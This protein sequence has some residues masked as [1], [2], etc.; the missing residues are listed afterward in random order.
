MKYL[1]DTHSLIW[2]LTGDAQ[3]SNRARQLIEAEE[4]ELLVSVASLWEM[5]IKFSIGKLDLGQPFETLFPQQ[6]ENNSIE[7]LSIAVEH[8]HT[9]CK[10]P[11][12]HRDPFDRL[13]IAQAQVEK[14]PVVSVDT[15]FDTYGTRREW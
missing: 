3:L 1:L 9:V 14:L 8:L 4:N 13:I 12:Y 7:I 10:L 2:F 11:F 6:L 15:V 5:A